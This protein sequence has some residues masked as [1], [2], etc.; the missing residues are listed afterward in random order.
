MKNRGSHKAPSRRAHKTKSAAPKPT[1]A[2]SA[3]TKPAQAATVK[4]T[5]HKP[6]TPK[7]A[8]PT[9]AAPKPA[10]QKPPAQAANLRP[11]TRPKPAFPNKKVQPQVAEF[12]AR[13]PFT[14]GRRFEAL[15]AFLL[16]QKNIAEELFYYG[17]KT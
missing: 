13:L 3:A 1:A 5:G 15:R 9:P 7:P 8:A 4:N 2:K 16:R 6:A 11:T 14:Q 12:P 17:P 10:P